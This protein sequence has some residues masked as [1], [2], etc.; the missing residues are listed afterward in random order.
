MNNLINLKVLM[1]TILV[2]GFIVASCSKDESEPKPV[3]SGFEISGS[4]YDGTYL[5]D[6]T[7]TQG[8]K[9]VNK[10]NNSEYLKTYKD[11]DVQMWGFFKLTPCA[12][13]LYYKIKSSDPYPPEHGWT[14]GQGYDKP[15]FKVTAI[16]K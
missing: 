12:T 11:E 8:S 2:A 9:Y 6:T 15:N 1:L 4:N 16:Y 7:Y 13:Y 3:P 10:R 14:C 5:L